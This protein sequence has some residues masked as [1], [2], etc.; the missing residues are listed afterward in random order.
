MTIFFTVLALVPGS[1]RGQ[2]EVTSN[3]ALG[4]GAQLYD[5]PQFE[6][7]SFDGSSGFFRM[8]LNSTV[9]FLRETNR[10]VG[11]GL[12]LTVDTNGFRDIQPG[13]G[14]SLLLPVH[15]DFP[16]VLWA[17][18]HYDY[19]GEHAGGFGGRLWWG[20]HNHNHFNPYNISFGLWVE[21]K[22]NVFGNNDLL[23][24]GGVD[25]DLAVLVAPWLWLARWI[26]GP[27]RL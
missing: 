26:H 7:G 20:A 14:L 10:D 22:A 12:Y 25:L 4:G 16:L 1:A 23:I 6:E 15:R 18:G 9:T 21:V 27:E 8:G 3:L 11:L 13:A 5:D 24:V 19:D 17:G 2:T